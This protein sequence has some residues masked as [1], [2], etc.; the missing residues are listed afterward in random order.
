M[1][2]SESIKFLNK[3]NTPALKEKYHIRVIEET[4]LGRRG[5]IL[6]PVF[7]VYIRTVPDEYKVAEIN[8]IIG[9]AYQEHFKTNVLPLIEIRSSARYAREYKGKYYH[10]C[11]AYDSPDRDFPDFEI[12]E[13][14]KEGYDA[15]LDMKQAGFKSQYDENLV[16]RIYSLDKAFDEAYKELQSNRLSKKLLDMLI[17]KR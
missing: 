1:D 16:V 2:Y 8:K 6:V 11:L 5:G 7:T 15:I 3:I 9:T 12:Y 13:V 10:M 14:S 4:T 17:D